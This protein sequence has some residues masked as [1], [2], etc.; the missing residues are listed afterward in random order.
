MTEQEARIRQLLRTIEARDARIAQQDEDINIFA[1]LTVDEDAKQYAKETASLTV[2]ED[3]N[4]YAKET[5][6][7]KGLAAPFPSAGSRT[8]E[9]DNGSKA[10][11]H[12]SD[13]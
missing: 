12:R 13:F 8:T 6:S 4:E 3:A 5:A 7:P 10:Y 1:N 9:S 2:E 11:A